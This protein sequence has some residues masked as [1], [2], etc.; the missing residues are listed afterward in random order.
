MDFQPAT[1]PEPTSYKGLTPVVSND[2]LIGAELEAER[3]SNEANSFE[4]VVSSLAS[5]IRKRW[6]RAKSNKTE[7]EQKM[8]ADL[9][10]R[11]GEYESDKLGAI[12]E[13]GGSEAF[14]KLTDQ[15]CLAAMSWIRDILS[16]D[17]PWDLTPTPIP[18][19]NPN[20][21]QSIEQNAFTQLAQLG[22]ADPSSVAEVTEMAKERMLEDIRKEANKRMDGMERKIEDQLV[23]CNWLQHF[24]DAMDDFVTLGIG[25]MRVPTLRTKKELGW[26]QGP[27]GWVP[28]VSDK[29]IPSVE[30]VSPLNFYISEDTVDVNSGYVI[31]LYPSSRSCLAALRDTPGY[32]REAIEEVLDRYGTRGYRESTS[33]RD[34]KDD[35]EDREGT[36]TELI[37]CLLF[38]GNIQGRVLLD[39]GMDESS[40]PD[41]LSEYPVECW[42]VNDIVI[43]AL[44]NDDPLGER[45][46]IKANY[47]PKAGSFW[48]NGGV[49]RK[50]SDIQALA[51]SAVR[52]LD[53]NMAIASGPMVGVAVNRLAP[54]EDGSRLYPWKVFQIEEGYSPTGQPPLTFFQPEMNAGVLLQVYQTLERMA[55]NVTSIPAYVAG[56][57]SAGAAGR[58]SSGLSMLMGAAAKTI[59]FVVGNLDAGLIEPAIRKLYTYN[60]LYDTDESIKGD[61]RPRA[62][63]A[64]RLLIKEQAQV[65]RNEFLQATN[66]PTDLQIMGSERRAGLLRSI[67]SGLDLDPDEVAPTPE[68]MA[69]QIAKQQMM[70]QQQQQAQMVQPQALQPDGSPKGG[71]ENST[72]NS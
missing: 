20:I 72:F 26:Q 30:R 3:E 11:N 66:N 17:K 2:A 49:P 7:T 57:N 61:A 29:I 67:A 38:Y 41:P 68:E 33:I 56:D 44:I 8:L 35:L 4:P 54:G 70:L 55:D 37:D 6:T 14:V 13:F 48:G 45:P 65:R 18:D 25:I 47:S 69:V 39:F 27:G 15:K 31:E 58:T 36:E 19:L 59:K 50:M 63:G 62:L 52:S 71:R 51:N 1:L 46:Y 5:E 40:I 42:S 43:K 23:E 12:R 21:T 22:M 34:D 16:M 9:R 60:M 10:Q 24:S 64:T 53:N 32:S 28:K